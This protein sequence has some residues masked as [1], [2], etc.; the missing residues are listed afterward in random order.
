MMTWNAWYEIQL[1]LGAIFL[2]LSLEA[3]VRLTR[4]PGWRQAAILGVVLG[5]ALLVDQ[6]STILAWS[7]A[8]AVLLLWLV[9]RPARGG[10][11]AWVKLRMV[12]L[13]GRGDGGSRQPADHRHG[14]ADARR[15]GDSVARAPWRRTTGIPAPR[16]SG[17][18][19][20]RRESAS[21]G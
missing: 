1:A 14:S 11:A 13:A 6:E 12:A 5:A 3:A 19:R 10:V 7:L 21:S 8:A 15:P 16:W 4:R 18:S 9:R 17:Y 2:P 20:P